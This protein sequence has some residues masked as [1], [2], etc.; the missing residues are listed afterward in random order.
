MTQRCFAPY[1]LRTRAMQSISILMRGRVQPTV[2]R[3]GGLS[4]K[5][6]R[7]TSFMA[8]KSSRFARNTPMRTASRSELPEA[9]KMA[10]MFCNTRRVS[11]RMSPSSISFVAR[12]DRPLAGHEDESIAHN[13]LRVDTEGTRPRGRSNHLTHQSSRKLS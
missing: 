13:G 11:E 8:A 7:K 9:S 5:N 4:G 12:I 10:A 3:A 1:R 6:S 2:V